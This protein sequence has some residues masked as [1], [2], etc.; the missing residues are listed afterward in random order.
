M[1]FA[2]ILNMGVAK[3]APDFVIIVVVNYHYKEGK[4]KE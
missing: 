1:Y 2:E 3:A 4:W